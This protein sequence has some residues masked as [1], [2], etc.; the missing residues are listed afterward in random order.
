MVTKAKTCSNL[1][2]TRKLRHASDSWSHL[3][4]QELLNF[5]ERGREWERSKQK[6]LFPIKKK[7]FYGRRRVYNHKAFI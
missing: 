3:K 2:Q 1:Y 6:S 7:A 4:E 5:T